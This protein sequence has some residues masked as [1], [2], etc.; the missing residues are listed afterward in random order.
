MCPIQALSNTQPMSKKKTRARYTIYLHGIVRF[1][2]NLTP[3]R[4]VEIEKKKCTHFG[5]LFINPAALEQSCSPSES[6]E[7]LCDVP[8]NN[9]RSSKVRH[10]TTRSDKWKSA[11]A[12]QKTIR[13]KRL[14]ENGRKNDG[15]HNEQERN[16]YNTLNKW[17]QTNFSTLTTLWMYQSVWGSTLPIDCCQPHSAIIVLFSSIIQSICYF[18]HSF[19]LCSAPDDFVS[20]SFYFALSLSLSLFFFSIT[21]TIRLFHIVWK[22]AP[23]AGW[24]FRSTFSLSLFLFLIH[25]ML[26]SV[27]RPAYLICVS[28][29]EERDRTR[30]SNSHTYRICRPKKY[31]L[32]CTPIESPKRKKEPKNV[33][34]WKYLYKRAN[35]ISL[36]RY[37]EHLIVFS[38][39]V[40]S[41]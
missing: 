39:L 14:K 10:T 23:L 18:R 31:T 3:S 32:T 1:T 16:F 17:M 4:S 37:L 20:L 7:S 6:V 13:R 27:Q 24:L 8:I 36:A 33:K 15:V 30:E 34:A 35:R 41:G 11:N 25:R 26:Y 21:P 5:W 28:L 40:W 22:C 19:T 29:F 2:Q 12:K 9:F 38:R